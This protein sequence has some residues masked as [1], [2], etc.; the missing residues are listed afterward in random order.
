MKKPNM[1]HIYGNTCH[2]QNNNQSSYI[3]HKYISFEILFIDNAYSFN[4]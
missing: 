4:V 2:T 1:L 3:A